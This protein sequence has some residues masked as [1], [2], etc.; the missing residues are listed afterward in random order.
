[1]EVPIH[2]GIWKSAHKLSIVFLFWLQVAVICG[3][4]GLIK[5]LLLES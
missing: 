5:F 1:M 3:S 4:F 2:V